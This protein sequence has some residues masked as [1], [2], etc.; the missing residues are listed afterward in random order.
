M[1]KEEIK[2]NNISHKLTFGQE[3]AD[4]LTGFAG[5]WT[6]IVL[7]MVLLII[8]MILNSYFLISYEL[9]KPWDP[10]PFILLNLILSCLAAV[11]A[12]IIL[13]SQNREAQRDR[14]RTEY[15]YKINKKAEREIQNIQKEL[16]EIKKILRKK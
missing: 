4:K 11:Q 12:P 8:W 7:L 1:K 14:L 3:A 9:G 10:Y 16:D 2:P 5:S 15:D 6:F 13:M